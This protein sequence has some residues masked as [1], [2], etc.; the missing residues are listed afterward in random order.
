[1]TNH[2]FIHK[3]LF[4]LLSFQAKQSIHN[5]TASRFDPERCIE[6]LTERK[7]KLQVEVNNLDEAI[8]L[9]RS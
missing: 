2:D 9:L 4:P 5:Y 3:H 1:M 6:T 7:L 8:R